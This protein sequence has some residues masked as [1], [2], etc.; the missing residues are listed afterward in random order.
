MLVYSSGDL[1]LLEYII[2]TFKGIRILES[3]LQ[4]QCSLLVVD[5]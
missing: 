4:D 1:N 2:P 5:R 3:Q